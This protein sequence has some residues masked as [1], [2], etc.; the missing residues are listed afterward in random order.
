MFWKT[1]FWE[2]LQ[3]KRRAKEKGQMASPK[4][5]ERSG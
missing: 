4:K 3:E 1:G 2:P 5:D